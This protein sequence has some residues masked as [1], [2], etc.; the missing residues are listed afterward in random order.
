MD[1]PEDEIFVIK[2]RRCK[3]CGGL[4]TSEFGV[5]EG[6]GHTCK[7]KAKV[8]EE[9]REFEKRQLSLFNNT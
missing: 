7:K 5:K 3:R 6:Y 4:L 1:K 2:A 9:Q 8:E